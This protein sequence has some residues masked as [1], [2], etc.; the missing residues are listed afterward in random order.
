MFT[1][2]IFH[3]IREIKNK[4]LISM[5]ISV[6]ILTICMPGAGTLI[7]AICCHVQPKYSIGERQWETESKA[8]SLWFFYDM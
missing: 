4:I 1:L 2:G 6:D 5:S 3:S 7:Y 8:P